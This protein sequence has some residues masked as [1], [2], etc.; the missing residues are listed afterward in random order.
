MIPEQIEERKTY[1]KTQTHARP[2]IIIPSHIHTTSRRE[3]SVD[4]T[5][6]RREKERKKNTYIIWSMFASSRPP[7]SWIIYGGGEARPLKGVLRR[8]P[9]PAL[10]GSPHPCGEKQAVKEDTTEKMVVKQDRKW[11][12]CGTSRGK[13]NRGMTR[14]GGGIGAQILI[15]PRMKKVSREKERALA[16]SVS[17]LSYQQKGCKK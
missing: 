8:Q 13:G 1:A 2:T 5:K 6:P 17:F 11:E 3:E 16:C 4:K 15:H 9:A 10:P 12:D 14:N 7:Y